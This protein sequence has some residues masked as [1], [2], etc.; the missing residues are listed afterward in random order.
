MG[1]G[2]WPVASGQWQVASG[3]WSVVSGQWPVASGQWSVVSGQWQVVSGQWAETVNF[4]SLD[5][6]VLAVLLVGITP[7]GDLGKPA[8]DFLSLPFCHFLIL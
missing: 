3:Q 2:Q 1:S 7:V 8:L 6:L 5:R 4:D